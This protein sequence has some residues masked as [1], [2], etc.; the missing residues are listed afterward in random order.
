L[1]VLNALEGSAAGDFAAPPHPA[2]SADR[3][4]AAPA[5]SM[6]VRPVR[7]TGRRYR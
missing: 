6:I 5:G 2:V 3:A 4:S 1:V 7:C